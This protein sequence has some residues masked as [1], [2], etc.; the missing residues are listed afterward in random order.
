M[1]AVGQFGDVLCVEAAT[2]KEVWRKHL[3]KNFSGKMMS[4]WGNSESPLIDGGKLICTPGGT[5]GTL[6][7]LDKMTGA[8]LWQTRDITDSAAY[9]SVLPV[10]L[11]G[12]HQLVQLTGASVFDSA[13]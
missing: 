12:V 1:Y 13:R 2:G 10:E 9:S 3:N 11:G 4:G 6:L 5:N 8:T 7:A